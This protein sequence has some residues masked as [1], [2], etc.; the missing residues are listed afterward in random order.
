MKLSITV[1]SATGSTVPHNVRIEASLETGDAHRSG[2]TGGTVEHT[3]LS[4]GLLTLHR[5]MTTTMM[6]VIQLVKRNGVEQGGL[7]V[8]HE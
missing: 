7:I 2:A 1:S 3:G 5:R 6:M 4:A 8:H